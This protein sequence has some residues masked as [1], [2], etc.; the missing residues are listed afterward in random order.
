[1]SASA[2]DGLLDSLR[3]GKVDLQMRYRFEFADDATPGLKHAYA[4]TLRTALGY[5]TGA[6]HD[7]SAYLEI[8]DVRVIGNDELYNDGGANA[9]R[10]RAVIVDPEGTE[11]NQAF[12]RYSGL[13]RS[14]ITFGRQELTHRE[15]PLHRFLGN[16][17]FR[18]NMQTYDA[19]RISSLALPQTV[20]DYAYIWNVNRP[21]G[22]R[23]SSPDAADFRMHSH[24]LNA[25]W[26]GLGF[27][28][29]EGYAYL[30]DFNSGV[31]RRFSSAT[32]GARL[33]GDHALDGKLKFVY[34]AE[35]ARQS[36]YADNP[37]AIAVGYYDLF[38]GASYAL[39]G[40]IESVSAKLEYEVLQG[41]GGFNAF[42]TP[43]GTNH[44]FQGHADRFL[45]TPGDGV[46][47]AHVSVGAKLFGAQFTVIYHDFR[48]DHDGYRYGSEWDVVLERPLRKN[49]LAGLQYADYRADRN[50]T[51]LERNS[52]GG[53]VYD[54]ARFWAYLQFKY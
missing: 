23:N 17:G 10:D 13:P 12:L 46:R 48:A 4:S 15:A 8:E 30:L 29:L 14:V 38:A 36:D 42:Q 2:Q 27:A 45:V 44:A 19:L 50:Q 52:A 18:Q 25:Q 51:N 37:N 22:E 34:A 43:L 41:K 33:Q 39:G 16:V 21:F 53:Q 1:M 35:L 7:V 31:S 28:K 5:M 49:L 47:D 6:F 54:L 9:V 32:Y 40:A 3:G 26:S 20:L 11:F 24:A